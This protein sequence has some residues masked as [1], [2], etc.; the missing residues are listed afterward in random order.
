MFK[1]IKTSRVLESAKKVGG[2]G[3][4]GEREKRKKNMR[5]VRTRAICVLFTEQ[6]IGSHYA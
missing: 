1:N 3:W 5:H 2:R 4:E 6:I